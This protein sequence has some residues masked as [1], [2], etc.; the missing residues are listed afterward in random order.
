[1]GFELNSYD[2]CVANKTIDGQQCTIAW[3]V[4]NTKISHDDDKLVTKVIERIEKKVRKMSVTRW[5]KHV[6][7][8][9][10]IKFFKDGTATIKMREYI[11]EA[12]NNFGENIA[13]T[14]NTPAKKNL[15]ENARRFTG[16]PSTVW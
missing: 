12:I 11:E 8:G 13:Q 15:F 6:F 3:Y 4:D 16:R 7:L 14:A 5:K 10:D 1:M 2:T 9:M